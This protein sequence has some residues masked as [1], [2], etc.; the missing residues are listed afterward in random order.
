[1]WWFTVRVSCRSFPIASGDVAAFG[2]GDR[3]Q[4]ARNLPGIR[5]GGTTCFLM[6]G[7]IM[8]FLQQR[9]RQVLPDLRCLHRF[10]GGSRGALVHVL[11]NELRGR[12][13]TV[14]FGGAGARCKTELFPEG[15]ER[16]QRIDEIKEDESPSNGSALPEDMA[17]VVSFLAG[18]EGG[19]INS[20]VLRPKR[21]LCSTESFKFNAQ[22]C[23]FR[24]SISI[25]FVFGTTTKFDRKEND[26]EKHPLVITGASSGFGRLS[27]T[28][29][30][31]GQVTPFIASMRENRGPQCSTGPKK[32][33][34]YANDHGVWPC[35][36]S[37]WTF[38]SQESCKRSHPGNRLQRT[39]GSMW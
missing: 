22:E 10:Q 3:D 25:N 29:L 1:M 23:R 26:H 28:R 24:E 38:P 9:Y 37:N 19:W 15:Q 35:V 12:N 11:A 7:R 8:A 34:K 27:G 21:R 13:I 14:N 2:Q 31:H 39:V 17:N 33:K 36:P 4:L 20:Q 16:R 30:W 18:P 6:G 32:W 5:A